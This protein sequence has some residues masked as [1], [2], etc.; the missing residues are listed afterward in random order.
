MS[1]AFFVKHSDVSITFVI[2][3]T[4]DLNV[5]QNYLLKSCFKCYPTLFTV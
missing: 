4:G 5:A 1:Y 3:G 2:N